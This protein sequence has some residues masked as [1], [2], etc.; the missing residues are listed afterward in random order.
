MAERGSPSASI[1]SAAGS[2][3]ARRAVPAAA[4][5]VPDGFERALERF[6]R[7]KL[8]RV[9]LVVL[10]LLY[11]S[12]IYAPLIAN[13]RP[14]FAEVIDR[15]AYERARL[16][17]PGVAAAL[18][19]ELERS[20]SGPGAPERSDAPSPTLDAE[21][22]AMRWRLDTLRRYLAREERAPLDSLESAADAAIAAA[23]RRDA[24]EVQRLAGE[25]QEC[26]RSIAGEFAPR[27]PAL[28][29]PSATGKRLQP[30]RSWPLFAEL[31]GPE[32][33]WMVLGLLLLAF[34]I[35]NGLVDHRWL[36]GDRRRIRAHRKTKLAVVVAV[37]IAAAGAV[38]ALGGPS[39]GSALAGASPWKQGLE[40]G[41]ILAERV[42]FPPIPYGV[43]ETNLTETSRPPSWA[44]P[45]EDPGVG[46][47]WG[48]P[49]SGSRFR[50]LLGTDALGRDLLARLVHGG[51]VS[52]AIGLI[53]AA[54]L[55][56]LGTAVGLFAGYLGG[57]VD[58]LASRGIEVLQCFPAFFLILTASALIPEREL[59]PLLTITL[60][61]A[62]VGWTGVARLARAEVLRLKGHE[63]VLA[64]RALG[65]SPVRTVF[66]HVLPNALGPILV[67][68][69]FAVASG[70]L[71]ESAVSFLG[72][73][74]RLPVPSW[75]ALLQESRSV[76]TWWI[77]LFP[78]FAVFAAVLCY[79][80]LGEGLR[81]ALDPRLASPEG[82]GR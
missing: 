70:I 76:E 52:L 50:H 54:V 10:A 8:A 11:A 36:R 24:A 72:F 13:D 7:R 64:A 40:S 73:G 74:V 29:D 18:C 58:G 32:A 69:A 20:P 12:A 66:R 65:C 26:A 68:A 34:P 61:I 5:D 6:R 14:Y 17:L 62:C 44:E 75:G 51:R 3:S 22:S 9:A 79:N 35:W 60:V 19:G 31:S 67:A 48:E 57:W 47:R 81:D 53:S 56:I 25:V 55:S 30:A 43:A 82:P 2:P 45:R 49:G 59:H 77:Q 80:L 15:G 33:G 39:R 63:F 41:E 23:R 42:S 27:G 1:P 71:M 16:S 78:G 37:A 46:V 21:R 38:S 4:A 28:Q